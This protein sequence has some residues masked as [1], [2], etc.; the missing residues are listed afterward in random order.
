MLTPIRVLVGGGSFARVSA[1]RGMKNRFLVEL[2]HHAV[3][4]CVHGISTTLLTPNASRTE[5]LAQFVVPG[6][7]GMS[8]LISSWRPWAYAA[9]TFRA[10]RQLMSSSSPPLASSGFKDDVYL[11]EGT[12][13]ET[14]PADPR[15]KTIKLSDAAF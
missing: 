1:A 2:V 13:V 14:Y 11:D 12:N 3:I 8:E 10:Y 15:R 9:W 5:A 4:S 7:A 6:L